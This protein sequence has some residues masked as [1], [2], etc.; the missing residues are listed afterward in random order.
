MNIGASV[1]GSP[2]VYLFK[3]LMSKAPISRPYPF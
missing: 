3:S 1:Y 2:N